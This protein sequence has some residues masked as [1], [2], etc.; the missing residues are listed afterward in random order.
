M[1]ITCSISD[2]SMDCSHK[3][4]N[5]TELGVMMT[6]DRRDCK[7]LHSHSWRNVS[8]VVGNA[9]RFFVNGAKWNN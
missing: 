8:F 4:K 1:P 9:F 5:Y 2:Y 3:E 6:K 7:K